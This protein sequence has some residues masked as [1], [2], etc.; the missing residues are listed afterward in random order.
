MTKVLV[1][2]QRRFHFTKEFPVQRHGPP[3]LRRSSIEIDFLTQPAAWNFLLREKKKSCFFSLPIFPHA[4]GKKGKKEKHPPV[5]GGR[6][7]HREWKMASSL[8]LFHIRRY[9]LR[10]PSESG[11]LSIVISRSYDFP[12]FFFSLCSFA[13]VAVIDLSQCALSSL[14]RYTS[15]SETFPVRNVLCRVPFSS[16]GQSIPF[17]ISGADI[18]RYGLFLGVNKESGM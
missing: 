14:V 2:K 16:G 7:I 11:L 18:H 13:P 3:S 8:L 15:L 10:S 9:L 5:G 17:F 4:P 1:F 12:S 6:I